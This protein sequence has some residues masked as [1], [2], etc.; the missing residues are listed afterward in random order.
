MW[1]GKRAVVPSLRRSNMER[2]AL[3]AST[4]VMSPPAERMMAAVAVVPTALERF[5]R[6]AGDRRRRVPMR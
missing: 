6:I 1:I 3:R 5:A 4:T 2:N